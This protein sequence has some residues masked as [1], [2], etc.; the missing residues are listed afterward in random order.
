MTASPREL[1]P[2]P[3]IAPHPHAR[4]IVDARGT[5]YATVTCRCGHDLGTYPKTRDGAG[6][7]LRAWLTHLRGDTANSAKR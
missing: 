1:P 4:V 5:G 3:D 7:V 2:L 6:D